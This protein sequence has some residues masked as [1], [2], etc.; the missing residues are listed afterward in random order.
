MSY[1]GQAP[2]NAVLTSS[3]LADG[4]VTT[5]KLAT[6]AVTNEKLGS[7]SVTNTKIL[8]N[9]ITEAKLAH[10]SP[11]YVIGKSPIDPTENTN[12][13]PI[14]QSVTSTHGNIVTSQAIKNYVEAAIAAAINAI[15]D[16]TPV[17]QRVVN[18]YVPAAVISTHTSPVYFQRILGLDYGVSSPALSQPYPVGVQVQAQTINWEMTKNNTYGS[19]KANDIHFYPEITFR[20]ANGT[21]ISPTFRSTSAAYIN[22]SNYRTSFS[23]SGTISIPTFI[24]ENTSPIAIYVGVN[25]HRSSNYDIYFLRHSVTR[26]TGLNMSTNKLT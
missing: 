24:L 22:T 21:A 4:V 19:S 25:A 9:T 10:I 2:S 23:V 8:D 11:G 26:F 3:Q 20:D 18:N 16:P 6:G 7:N 5:P 12:L 17:V 15:P 14:S 1:L 13:V